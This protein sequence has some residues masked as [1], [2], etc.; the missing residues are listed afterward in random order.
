[1]PNKKQSNQVGRCES[2]KHRRVL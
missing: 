2:S 1:M